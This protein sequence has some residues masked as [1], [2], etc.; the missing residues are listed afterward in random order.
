MVLPIRIIRPCLFDRDAPDVIAL[1]VDVA[2]SFFVNDECQL[3][4]EVVGL[5]KAGLDQPSALLVDIASTVVHH[6][7]GDAVRKIDAELPG[8]IGVG[9]IG[10]GVLELAGNDDVE[11]F[12]DVPD[13]AVAD[14]GY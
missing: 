12:I 13:L 10:A 3:A 2:D 5:L 4:A 9:I 14:D 6:G 11:V 1:T 7:R 8:V